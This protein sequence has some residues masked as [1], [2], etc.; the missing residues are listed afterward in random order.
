MEQRLKKVIIHINEFLKLFY[1]VPL[2]DLIF[3]SAYTTKKLKRLSLALKIC[4]FILQIDRKMAY[5]W[6][7][8]G[9]ILEEY[10]KLEDAAELYLKANKIVPEVKF[11]L[12][13]GRILSKLG[14]DKEASSCYDEAIEL[15]D[16]DPHV[17]ESKGDFYEHLK[18]YKDALI[19]YEK[20]IEL[21]PDN[22]HL[23]FSRLTLFEFYNYNQEKNLECYDKLIELNPNDAYYWVGKAEALLKDRDAFIPNG[24]IVGSTEDYE[25]SLKCI[26]KAVELDPK[27]LRYQLM[28]GT[29][30]EK[31]E[32][33]EEALMSYDR[34]I[35]S[36]GWIRLKNKNIDEAS[37]LIRKAKILYRFGRSEDSIRCLR[38]AEK[39]NPENGKIWMEIGEI[40]DILGE[41]NTSDFYY[42]KALQLFDTEII[43]NPTERNFIP[44]GYKRIILEKLG[45]KFEASGNY[46]MALQYYENA[47]KV[48]P[49]DFYLWSCK[50]E[51]FEKLGNYDEAL[52]C[53]DKVIE[54]SQ[55]SDFAALNLEIKAKMYLKIS[56]I[57]DA[58]ECLDL[59]IELDP[60][61]Q[62]Y[63]RTKKEIITKMKSR[64]I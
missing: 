2:V 12:R 10:G 44:Q 30:L 49:T 17:W 31:L 13:R 16:N 19:C 9:E 53:V 64:Q 22:K 58:L 29:L 14:Q 61:S 42:H 26:D 35:K 59:A 39:L 62:R 60:N 45:S 28:K 38:N 23:W 3:V 50:R 47:I 20:A 33:Y 48:D 51:I 63:T 25:K 34:A 56:K 55:S 57:E 36:L 37:L 40:F 5:A 41:K 52:K 4:D 6:S 54:L 7:L 15:S 46:E 1:K 8:K 24:P 21:D 32:K 27:N 11:W 18:K 43:A